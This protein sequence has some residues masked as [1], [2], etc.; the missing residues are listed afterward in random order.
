MSV[1]VLLFL[2]GLVLIAFEVFVPG[3]VLG[4]CG[5]VLIAIG[6]ALA[7][8]RHGVD[9]GVLAVAAGLVLGG[10]LVYAEF[11]LL[12]KTRFGQKM[13]LNSAITATSQPPPAEADEVV[14]KTAEALTMLAPSGYVA[15]EGKRYEAFS[16]D[17]LVEKGTRLRVTAVDN[18]TL[19]VTKL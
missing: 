7:F 11:V 15:L 19:K 8:M 1:I 13:F 16:L 17:G 4:I 2:V 10:I 9:G 5:G 3:A 14:G 12:P 18:F 6:C